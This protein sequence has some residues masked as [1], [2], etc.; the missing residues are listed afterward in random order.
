[1]IPVFLDNHDM[2]RF[3]S[4]RGH[5]R[6]LLRAAAVQMQQPGPPVILY[7]T[8]IGLSQATST[9]NGGHH[10]S[11]TPMAW[12]DDQDRDLLRDYRALIRERRGGA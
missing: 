2:D 8:E 6:A 5:K 12:G 9:Q 11:R 3:C 7:G 4:S 10:L 1:M